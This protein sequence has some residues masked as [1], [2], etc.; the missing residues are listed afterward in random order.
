MRI[1]S[2]L[3]KIFI[4]IL[5]VIIAIG[6]TS[7]VSS[8]IAVKNF[9]DV[10]VENK[11]NK[12][13]NSLSVELCSSSQSFAQIM[14]EKSISTRFEINGDCHYSVEVLF[15]DGKKT[16]FSDGYVTG[17]YNFKDTIIITDEA[18]SIKSTKTPISNM[19]T[20]GIFL[21]V[22][23]ILSSYLFYKIMSLFFNRHIAKK[24]S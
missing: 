19:I 10:T 4:I 8:L 5:S 16:K 24:N 2:I 11:S 22:G 15:Q 1:Q 20:Q 3:I 7:L 13:I 12:E 18:N 21:I 17:G 9:S 14:P 23:F 6:V